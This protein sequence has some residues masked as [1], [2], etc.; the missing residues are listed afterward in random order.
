MVWNARKSKIC[1]GV[2]VPTAPAQEKACA[3]IACII[4]L[5]PDRYRPVFFRMILKAL[6]TGA[7]RI[8]LKYGRIEGIS[9]KKSEHD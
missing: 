1:R 6:M 8:S 7:Y 3:V 9:K 4:T 2:T 5:V